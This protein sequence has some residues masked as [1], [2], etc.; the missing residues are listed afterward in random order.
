MVLC[1]NTFAKAQSVFISEI[2]YDNVGSDTG[3]GIEITGPAGTDLSCY[4]ILL[5]NG[6]PTS[7]VNDQYDSLALSGI[8]DNELSGYGA[9]WFDLV[10]LQNGGSGATP[11]PD[12][13]ALMSS[14]ATGC[15]AAGLIQALSYEGAF[16]IDGSTISGSMTT[17]ILVVQE[18]DPI[19][20][21]LQ[22]FGTGTTYSDFSWSSD[23]TASPG[24]INSYMTFGTAIPGAINGIVFDDLNGNSVQDMGEPG[25]S[26]VIVTL[27]TGANTTT[28]ASGNYSFSSI[29]PGLYTVTCTPLALYSLTTTS[30]IS[31]TL[32]SGAT[33]TV[34]FG[35]TTLILPPD[36]KFNL[37]TTTINEGAG[38]ATVDI[39]IISPNANPT[40]VDVV[41]SGGTATAADYTYTSTTITFPA[42]SAAPISIM[43]PIIDDTSIES[44]ETI[45]L[46]LTNA[47]NGAEIIVDSIHTITINDND[48]MLSTI[49]AVSSIDASGI[50]ASIGAYVT[51]KGIVY[52]VNLRASLA[53]VQFTLRDATGG[54]GVF[55]DTNTYGYIVT[56]GDSIEITGFIDQYYGLLQIKPDTIIKYTSGNPLI[57]PTIVTALNESTESNLI[58]INGVT[59]VTPTQWTNT[60]SAF[61]VDVTDGTNSYVIRID[62]DVSLYGTTAPT[63]AFDII[64]IGSQFDI[65]V[66]YLDNYQIMPRYIADLIPSTDI[67]DQSSFATLYPNPGINYINISSD[68]TIKSVNILNLDGKN[69]SE[70]IINDMQCQIGIHELSSGIYL[71]RVV[72]IDR[73]EQFIK[74]IKD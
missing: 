17:D 27:S 42:G 48:A 71:L 47:T 21:S 68:H 6:N 33:A 7:V 54:I 51:L 11:A 13:I 63:G 58:R 72:T 65:A 57:T 23:S 12:A 25:L 39:N 44:T 2:H 19:G 31:I 10:G 16:T 70:T 49:A 37:P 66:P 67:L 28:D 55:N 8:I 18:S 60:G 9:V 53:G 3:E 43:I 32:S 45:I 62:N 56:E 69:I 22:L 24:D 34:V 15:P 64:G 74:F 5:L 50:A 20:T 30:P 4:Y 40:S 35:M 52:G 38:T 36:V 46:T 61:N 59:L 26:G 41:I 73:A 1:I 29:M 14:G